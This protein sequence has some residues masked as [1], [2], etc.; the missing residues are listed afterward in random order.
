MMQFTE[1][2]ELFSLKNIPSGSKEAV[3]SLLMARSVWN[4]MSKEILC[5]IF[6]KL[7]DFSIEVTCIH[8]NKR[9]IKLWSV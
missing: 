4:N 3:T 9:R 2:I 6:W 7:L 5:K 1:N 8:K